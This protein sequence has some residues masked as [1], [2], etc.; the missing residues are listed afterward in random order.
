MYYY[1]D[2]KKV[3]LLDDDEHIAIAS[4]AASADLVR[5]VLAASGVSPRMGTVIVSKAS[6]EADGLTALDKAGA[7]LPV[8]RLDR[9]M[10]VPL[11]EVRVEMDTQRQRD[12]VKRLLAGT[13]L[14]VL[15]AEETDDR[16]VFR[17]SSG[18]PVDAL[19]AANRI[20]EA[21][22]PA[23]SSVRFVQFVPRPAV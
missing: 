20:F 12:A 1:A 17:P 2:G 16:L 13:D 23:A 22:H 11:P 9:A 4:S 5:E 15:V 18:K 6:I 8:F 19:E 21:A 10:M 3:E 14:G 7:L